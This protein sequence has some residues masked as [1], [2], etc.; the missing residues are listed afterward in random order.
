MVAGQDRIGH[1]KPP[2]A[3]T[4]KAAI[5]IDRGFGFVFW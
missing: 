5:G 1:E 4:K 3:Y 2:F